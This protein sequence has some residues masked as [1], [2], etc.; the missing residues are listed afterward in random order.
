MD[1]PGAEYRFLHTSAF[2]NA[3]LG[4]KYDMAWLRRIC[5]IDLSGYCWWVT[6]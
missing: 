5:S 1:I 3:V 4:E 2:S 6:R